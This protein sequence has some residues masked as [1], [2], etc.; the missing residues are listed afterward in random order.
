MRKKSINRWI[1]LC[2]AGIFILALGISALANFQENYRSVIARSNEDMD[3]CAEVA[4][5]NL[6]EMDPTSLIS[7]ENKGRY[8]EIRDILLDNARAFGVDN[9][10]VYSIDPKTRVRQIFFAV[11]PDGETDRLY[12]QILYPGAESADPLLPIEEKWLAGE[13]DITGS[14][15]DGYENFWFHAYRNGKDGY[16]YIISLENS[17]MLERQKILTS[18]LWDIIPISL[19]LL[20]G[21]IILL[22]LVRRRIIRPIT[23]I[24]DSMSRFAN[25]GYQHTEPIRLKSQDEIGQIAEAYNKMTGDISAYVGS[26]ESLNREKLEAKVQLGIARRIQ[27]GLVPEKITLHGVGFRACAMTRPAKEVGGDFYDCF[28]RD[29]QSVCI[30][31]GDVSDKGTTAAIF[32]AM[33]KTMIREKMM[34]G[35]SPAKALNQANDELCGQNP[36]G[37]FTTAFAAVLNPQAGELCYANAGHTRPVLL[38]ETPSFM[39]PEP[40]IVLGLYKGVDLKDHRLSLGPSEGILLYTDGVTEAVNP[41]RQF[42]GEQRLLDTVNSVS[43]SA[44]AEKILSGVCGAVVDFNACGEPFDDMAALVLLRTP[45]ESDDMEGPAPIG[46][47]AENDRIDIPVD[48]SSFDRIKQAV[49][50]LAGNTQETRMALLACDEALTNIVSY[51][52]ATKLAFSCEKQGDSLCVSFFDNGIPF[53]P[54]AVGDEK[55]FEELDS[56]GM[57]LKLIRQNAS[58][59]RYERRRDR[60]ELILNFNL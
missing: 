14:Y 38:G 18:F 21:M 10:C 2:F 27:Y 13:K 52:G 32:M 50:T 24:S 37:L 57:G 31:I 56:G 58:G 60:N 33:A 11:S 45:A 5:N 9:L 35:M 41:Q 47:S 44:D 17:V 4:N 42:F 30:L 49:I 53:D 28:Q 26:I 29:E 20:V 12:R 7:P 22:I 16:E 1:I 6:A 39:N 51:S 8:D 36:E 54:T 59:I 25:N 3:R 34:A 43:D 48:L 55:E 19:I 15:R 46:T 40:G 23:V